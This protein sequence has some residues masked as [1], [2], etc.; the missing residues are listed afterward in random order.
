MLREMTRRRFL[1]AGAAAAVA[2][3]LTD[4][5]FKEVFEPGVP[6]RET[7]LVPAGAV[8]L[9]AFRRKCVG[10]QLCVRNC[11]ERVLR[12]AR[13]PLRFLQPEMGFEHGYCRPSCSRCGEVCPAGAIIPVAREEKLHTHIGRAVWW[14]SRCLA[15]QEG[16]TCT[17]CERHC[18][19]KAIRLV[20]GVPMVDAVACIGCGACE[21]IFP[22]RPL[23]GMTVEGCK[24]H[25]VERPVSP[26]KVAYERAHPGTFRPRSQ[27]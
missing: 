17:V 10:C 19:V 12:P 16:I 1:E 22:A 11:P 7:P 27:I 9:S 24:G 14:K 21:Y 25:R 2:D 26:Q 23:P 6:V 8:S 15:A 4:G 20:K 13:A 18:P 3:K 5:G